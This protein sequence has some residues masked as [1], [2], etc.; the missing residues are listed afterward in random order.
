MSRAL[1]V[2]LQL[3]GKTYSKRG[4]MFIENVNIVKA[5]MV[6]FNITTLDGLKMMGTL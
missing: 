1:F 5:Y 3:Q 2:S 6:I 4:K